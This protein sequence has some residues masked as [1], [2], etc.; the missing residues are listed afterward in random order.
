MIVH[1]QT[2]PMLNFRRSRFPKPGDLI[3]YCFHLSLFVVL[4]LNKDRVKIL[5]THGKIVDCIFNVI[6]DLT[7]VNYDRYGT[8]PTSFSKRKTIRF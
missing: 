5:N 1:K 3:V 4:E 2:E 8:G 7:P 6:E